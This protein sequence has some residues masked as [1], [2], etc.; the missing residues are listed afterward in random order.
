MQLINKLPCATV[1]AIV[2][3]VTSVSAQGM[4]GDLNNLGTP[5]TGVRPQ[6]TGGD[7]YACVNG[8]ATLPSIAYGKGTLSVLRIGIG[9]YIVRFNRDVTY[10]VKTATIGLCGYVGVESPGEITTVRSV[11]YID[12][13][14]VTTHNSKGKR[15]NRS[16][17]LLVTCE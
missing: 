9:T 7:R 6:S 11:D 4:A 1:V 13:V 8:T 14:F 3:A 10:C 16:F 12:G 2:L 5:A 15:A 17:H